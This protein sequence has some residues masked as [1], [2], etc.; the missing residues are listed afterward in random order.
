MPT[1]KIIAISGS[2]R[3]GS[4]NTKLVQLAAKQLEAQ[5]VEVTQLDISSYNLPIYHSKI[6]DAGMPA[7]VTELHRKFSNHDGVFIAS[8]EY[9]AFPSPLLLNMLDW[10]SRYKH[11]EGGTKQAFGQAPFAIGSA[12]PSPFGGYRGACSLRQKLELGLGAHVL[13]GMVCIS[14]S[15]QAFDAMGDLINEQDGSTF[16]EVIS[17]LLIASKL[18]G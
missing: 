7:G 18:T 9:N 12:S 4:D 3:L 11:D 2:S 6:Q 5:G 14:A 8:P 15:Y 16:K 17:A 13:P 10:V 1:P